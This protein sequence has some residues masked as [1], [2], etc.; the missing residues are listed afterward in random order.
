MLHRLFSVS[1]GCVKVEADGTP[2]VFW[3]NKW[4]PICGHW[5][6][7]NNNG[8]KSVC[9]R[10]GYSGGE[11]EKA[12][13]AYAEDAIGLGR[14]DYNE[15]FLSCS[16]GCGDKGIGNK[17]GCPGCSAGNRVAIRIH[18]SGMVAGTEINSCEGKNLFQMKID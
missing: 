7:D 18:C 5:F 14:C 6:W 8:A 9:Q 16:I 3:D 2:K 10:L 13:D 11:V 15:D 17:N 12:N 4:S 1:D